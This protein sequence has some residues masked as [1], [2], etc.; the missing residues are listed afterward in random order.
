[1]GLVGNLEDRLARL[2]AAHDALL[3]RCERLELA[4]AALIAERVGAGGAPRPDGEP[5]AADAAR[6]TRRMLLGGGLAGVAGLAAGALLG[7]EPAAASTGTMQYGAN[8]NAGTSG[9]NLTSSAVDKVLFVQNTGAG[10]ALRATAGGVA[11]AATSTS[12]MAIDAVGTTTGVNAEAAN[13]IAVR[14]TSLT[15][16]AGIFDGNTGRGVRIIADQAQLTLAPHTAE[17]PA[18]TADA[19]VHYVGEVIC[20]GNGDLWLCVDGGTPG[21]WQKMGGPAS[22]GA[23]HVLP[24]PVR[25]YDSRPGTT[26]AVGLKTKFAA[27]ETRTLDCKA[28][29]SGVPADASA[30]V[31]TCLIVNAVAG[32]GNFTLWA[33]GA[34]K[35]SANTMVW[36]GSDGR[37][38]SLALSA[39]GPS[40]KVKVSPS[41]ATDLVVDVVGFYR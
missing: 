32:N 10:Q 27:N 6:T 34:A 11:L 28:N 31:V 23:T 9:T 8:N 35:P 30:I 24:T 19:A 18:P 16:T 22:A 4:N 25:I 39:L 17:R 14:A 3:D 12:S 15:G 41:I 5:V 40:A 13:G 2:E 38:S 21:T 33:D 37:H 26:P 7:G 29:A 36:G 1:M 20:D